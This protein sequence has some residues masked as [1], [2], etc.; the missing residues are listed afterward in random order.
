MTVWMWLIIVSKALT[1]L[2]LWSAFVLLLL[3]R[4]SQ[5]QDFFSHLVMRTFRGN[6]PGLAIRYIVS[7][8]AF[9]TRPMLSRVALGISVYALV[10][11]VEA[12]G[13]LMRKHWAEWLVILVTVS[14][15][16]LEIFEIVMRP[17][18]VK[19]GTLVGNVLI[20]GYLVKREYDKRAEWRGRAI[21]DRS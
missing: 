21:L 19:V 4:Q 2:L 6:P 17:N 9:I 12:I 10:E 15:I 18:A 3:A 14:F 20:L 5:P 1:A 16:P 8:T 13:L 7:N 11:S